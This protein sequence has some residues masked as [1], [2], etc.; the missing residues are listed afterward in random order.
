MIGHS[1]GECGARKGVVKDILCG[2]G[3]PGGSVA[4]RSELRVHFN[5]ALTG[6]GGRFRGMGICAGVLATSLER[7]RYIKVF[8]AS[9]TIHARKYVDSM[10]A[11]TECAD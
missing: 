5:E 11:F 8:T 9:H 10:Q 3:Q 2:V 7:I 4:G 1:I 6:L